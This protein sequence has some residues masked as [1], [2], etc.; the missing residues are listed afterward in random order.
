MLILAPAQSL[1]RR[2]V[3]P[4][5]VVC[6]RREARRHLKE[7]PASLKKVEA[8]VRA[9]LQRKKQRQ[10]K[11]DARQQAKYESLSEDSAGGAPASMH[12]PE[13]QH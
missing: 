10:Q 12:C 3:K 2:F 11:N 13:T 8:D 6:T 9:K 1:I 4:F 7:L 5:H